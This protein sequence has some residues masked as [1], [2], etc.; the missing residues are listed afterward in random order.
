M[1][2]TPALTRSLAAGVLA[3]LALAG[4]TDGASDDPSDGPASTNPPPV[5]LGTPDEPTDDATDEPTSAEPT[6]EPGTEPPTTADPSS[7]PAWL[8]AD[9]VAESGE[10][11]GGELLPVALRVGDHEGFDR[12]VLEMTGAGTPGW[13]VAYVPEAIA[14]GRGDRLDIDGDAVLEVRVSGTRYPEEGE[15][16]YD[17]P[18]ELD[19]EDVIEEVRYVGTFEGLTQLFIG[20]DDGPQQFRVFA[21]AEPARLVIDI[22]ED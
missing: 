2:T 17:G 14:D 20:V 19:G 21:L 5:D 13:H 1:T 15:E 4:C 10:L 22:R 6:T 3:A 12:V 11:S 18:M 7:L 9:T 8:P 16:H